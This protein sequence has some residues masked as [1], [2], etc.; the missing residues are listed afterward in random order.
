MILNDNSGTID[1]TEFL[2]ALHITSAGEGSSYHHIVIIIIDG[3]MVIMIMTQGNAEEKLRWAF[4]M[5]DV[6]GNGTIDRQE[7]K[8]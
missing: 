8:A 5:Y 6:D 1:F 2:L 7:M 3:H 4:R